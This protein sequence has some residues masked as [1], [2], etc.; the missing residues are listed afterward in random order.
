MSDE[1]LIEAFTQASSVTGDSLS[2]LTE[3]EERCESLYVDGRVHFRQFEIQSLD[4]TEVGGAQSED[5]DLQGVVR[6]LSIT[7][8]PINTPASDH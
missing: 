6:F 4:E 7:N 3:F 8:T 5:V 2:F 1:I